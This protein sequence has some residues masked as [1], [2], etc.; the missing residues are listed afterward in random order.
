MIVA[1]TRHGEEVMKDLY[2]RMQKS[3]QYDFAIDTETQ[4]KHPYTGKKDALIIGRM[5]IIIFSICYRG[6]SYS[7]PTDR[8]LSGY[9]SMEE[10]ADVLRP[11]VEDKSIRKVMHNANYDLSTFMTST[12]LDKWNNV[13]CTMIG[14]WLAREYVEKSL[15]ER[16]PFYGR[17]IQKTAGIEFTDL[18]D[19]STY[20]EMDVVVTDELYQM[21]AYGKVKRPCV[22]EHVDEKGE[23]VKTKSEFAESLL[24]GKKLRDVVTIVDGE[25]LTRLNKC[26]LSVQEIPAMR[27]N[28]RAELL[29]FPINR[30]AVFSARKKLLRS[31]NDA[32]KSVYQTAGRKFNLRSTKQLAE[33]MTEL[34][35]DS[36]V[37]SKKTGAPSFSAQALVKLAG[38]HS[39]IDQIQT[40]KDLDK[41]MSVYVGDGDKKHGLL[42]YTDPDDKIHCTI[43]SVGAVT[44]RCSC[45]NPNL[46]QIPSRKD[47]FKLKDCFVST[48]SMQSIARSRLMAMEPD[49]ALAVLKKMPRE[50]REVLL[51]LDYSQLEIRIMALLCKDPL[52]TEV[53]CDPKGD[54]HQTTADHFGVP[55]NPAAK[56]LNFLLLYGGQEYM[57]SEALSF[58]GVP[59]TK[60]QAAAYIRRHKETYPNVSAYRKWLLDAYKEDGFV[61]YFTGRTRT[62]EQTVNWGNRYEV[63]KAETTL[64]NNI[65]QGSGQD[66]VKAAIIRADYNGVFPDKMMLD[67]GRKIYKGSRDDHFDMINEQ[68]VPKV[69]NIRSLFKRHECRYLLQVHDE[70]IFTVDVRGAEECLKALGELMCLPH[71]LPG[72][73]DYTVPLAAEGG[74]G[75]TWKQAKGGDAFKT[76]EAR[77]ENKYLTKI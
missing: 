50:K 69:K 1:T 48:A 36:P 76:V 46:T 13:H 15:K 6:I 11:Y 57:L 3:G 65:C 42:E 43:N 22:I 70:V 51:C 10:W 16:A 66:F 19:L 75:L 68:V 37:K 18:Q 59:T 4:P 39:I 2:R 56:N 55:R 61:E 8:F 17:Y 20:A 63:H 62:L 5:E 28:V 40:Y 27:C 31:L 23:I 21:Q 32:L 47:T 12:T 25:S 45:S 35:I 29:G 24:D 67:K 52:M 14:A 74:I 7:F 54:I 9:P 72:T 53:L 30:F 49:E 77:M 73:T 41:T 44:G 33:V 26:I 64:G 71:Y 60:E 58:M 38:T 34:G